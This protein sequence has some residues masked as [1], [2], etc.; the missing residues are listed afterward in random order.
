MKKISLLLAILIMVSFVC[1]DVYAGNA[2]GKLGRGIANVATGWVEIP[3]EMI[4]VTE[5]DN[6]IKG[7]FVA[8]FTGLWK[9][10]S[11]TFCGVYEIITFP[12]PIP[13]EYAPVIEPE[14]VLSQD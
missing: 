14:Y 5:Q 2:I 3:K 4:N 10:I 6:D 8:P 7:F 11:R 9:G 12:L 1:T 13:A